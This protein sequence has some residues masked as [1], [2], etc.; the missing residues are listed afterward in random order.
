LWSK[1]ANAVPTNFWR[2]TSKAPNFETTTAVSSNEKIETSYCRSPEFLGPAIYIREFFP[3]RADSVTSFSIAL[4]VF[5]KV[6]QKRIFPVAS[7]WTTSC[8]LFDKMRAGDAR[9]FR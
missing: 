7:L 4:L 5:V 9:N 1:S 6:P 3:V 8:A 2:L